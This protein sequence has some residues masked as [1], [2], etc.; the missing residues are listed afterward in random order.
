[1][2]SCSPVAGG[3]VGTVATERPGD[4][5]LIVRVKGVPKG[6][7]V[8]VVVEEVRHGVLLTGR[9]SGRKE[10]DDPLLV[11]VGLR[12]PSLSSTT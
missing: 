5:L 6:H 2:E 4:E 3:E 8:P 7:P 10:S 11:C 1:M 12:T 9:H